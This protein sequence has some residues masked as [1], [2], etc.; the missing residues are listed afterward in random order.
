MS[1]FKY[2]VSLSLSMALM[3]V[4]LTSPI[5]Q[6]A[7]DSGMQAV[8]ADKTTADKTTVTDKKGDDDDDDDDDDD[9][10]SDKK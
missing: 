1:I 5:V 9:S 2:A 10:K 3:L 7:D 4:F 8:T 6:A